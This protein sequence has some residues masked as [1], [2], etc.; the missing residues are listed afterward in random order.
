M[1]VVLKFEPSGNP[2]TIAVSGGA[3]VN[4]EPGGRIRPQYGA[5]LV[6]S[7]PP[8]SDTYDAETGAEEKGCGGLG[9]GCR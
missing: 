6:Q 9:D 2:Q 8:G 4:W 7:S 3:S 5:A 1:G